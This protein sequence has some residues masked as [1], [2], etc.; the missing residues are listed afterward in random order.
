MREWYIGISF[1]ERC[2][3]IIVLR[4]QNGEN[5]HNVTVYLLAF[6][7]YHFVQ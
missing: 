2:I 3:A 5:L 1:L 6:F 4:A 7:V